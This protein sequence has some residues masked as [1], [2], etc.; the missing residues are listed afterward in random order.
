MGGKRPPGPPHGAVVGKAGAGLLTPAQGFSSL[1]QPLSQPSVQGAER[2]RAGP[3]RRGDHALGVGGE[4]PPSPSP[5]RTLTP[6]LLGF[7]LEA[8]DGSCTHHCLALQRGL[9]DLVVS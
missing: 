1:P 2:A 3:G 8:G 4:S 9:R 6:A 7:G 5:E